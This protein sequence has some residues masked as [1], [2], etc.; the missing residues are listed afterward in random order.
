MRNWFVMLCFCVET[1][2][3][4][5]HTHTHNTNRYAMHHHR[6]QA[7]HQLRLNVFISCCFF[8]SLALF[9]SVLLYL[10]FIWCV[11]SVLCLAIIIRLVTFH[12]FRAF[13]CLMNNEFLKFR[14]CQPTSNITTNKSFTLLQA[15]QMIDLTITKPVLLL[16]LLLLVFILFAYFLLSYFRFIAPF[17]LVQCCFGFVSSSYAPLFCLTA[18]EVAFI[19]IICYTVFFSCRVCVFF[20]NIWI[21]SMCMNEWMCICVLFFDLYFVLFHFEF[22]FVCSFMFEWMWALDV[23]CKA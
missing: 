14:M 4:Y 17:P 10:C 3:S 22:L 6:V 11:Q 7:V 13:R 9:L 21:V 18:V 20:L 12:I 19:R 8:L 16:L 15:I 5:T 2:S 1:N 23:W